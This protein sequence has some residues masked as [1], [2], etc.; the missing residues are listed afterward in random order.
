MDW[1]AI[2]A[3]HTPSR[4]FSG[5][6]FTHFKQDCALLQW[7]RNDGRHFCK[8][9]VA[10]KT[11]AGV[12]FKCME[13]CGLWKFA[14]AYS[15]EELRKTLHRVC[16]DWCRPKHRK[17]CGGTKLKAEFTSS[18]WTMALKGGRQ[19]RC[20]SCMERSS[21]R[22]ACSRCGEPHT[23]DA[24]ASIRDWERRDRKCKACRAEEEAGR[25][26]QSVRDR[27]KTCRRCGKA[28][29]RNEYVAGRDWRQSDRKCKACRAEEEAVR[30]L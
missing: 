23:R 7:N 22:E 8:Q 11:N 6:G 4:V 18:E 28:K 15:P 24:Y 2:E 20:H 29:T 16:I 12:P 21:N 27:K 25:E 9:C 30:E 26:Q 14:A 5:C 13:G 10:H 1:A 3:K 19:G 17:A